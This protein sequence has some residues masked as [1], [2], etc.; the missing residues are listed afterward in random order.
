MIFKAIRHLIFSPLVLIVDG[1]EIENVEESPSKRMAT[2][3]DDLTLDTVNDFSFSYPLVIN[4][5]SGKSSNNKTVNSYQELI[6]T[7][8]SRQDKKWRIKNK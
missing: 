2:P 3:N 8:A 7:I 5:K 1:E 6:N 4:I